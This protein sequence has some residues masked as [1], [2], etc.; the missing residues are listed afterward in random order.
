MDNIN[1]L[2]D[3]L[4]K[5]NNTIEEESKAIKKADEA[6]LFIKNILFQYQEQAIKVVFNNYP[7][8]EDGSEKYPHMS[9]VISNI[10]A[11]CTGI[12]IIWQNKE[13]R[14]HIYT[15]ITWSEIRDNEFHNYYA[16]ENTKY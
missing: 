1:K 13:T 12:D 14:E 4:I 6:R 9:P 5:A 2:I 3:N 8:N 7:H 10:N 15:F 11:F 16:K